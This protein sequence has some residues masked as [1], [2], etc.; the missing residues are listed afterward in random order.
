MTAILCLDCGTLCPSNSRFCLHCGI[1]LRPGHGPTTQPP[2]S[3]LPPE[4]LL[5]GRYR[6]ERQLGAGAFGRVYLAEDMAQ[7]DAPAVALKELLDPPQ[8]AE[9]D[10]HEAVVWFK[11]EVAT[12]LALGHPAIPTLRGY[13]AANPDSGPFYLAMEYIPGRT[14][15]QVLDDAGGPLPW[16]QVVA[17]GIALCDVLGYLHGQDPPCLFRDLT[18]PNIIL[19]IRTEA[20]VLIDFGLAGPLTPAHE[21]AAGTWGYVPLEQILG[22]AEPR[23]DLYALGAVLHALLSGQDPEGTFLRLQRE[24]PD[25]ELTL[26]AVFPPLPHEPQ[27]I[28]EPLSQVIARATA[29]APEDRYPDALTMAAAL[30]R[31]LW[32]P[33]IDTGQITTHLVVSPE[34]YGH[35]LTLADAIAMAPPRSRIEVRPGRYSAPLLIDKPLEIVGSGPAGEVLVETA[36]GECLRVRTARVAVHG[37]TLRCRTDPRH[38]GL[39]AVA[40]ESGHQTLDECRIESEA[41]DAIAIE[42]GDAGALVRHCSITSTH[43]T[44]IRSAGSRGLQVADCEIAGCGL[45]GLSIAG[46]QPEIRRCAIVNG[47]GAGAR[48]SDGAAGRLEACRLEG[49]AEAGLV[50]SDE[51]HPLIQDCQIRGNGGAA[52]VIGER[53]GGTVTGCDLRGNVGGPWQ[54]DLFSELRIDR[55]G[56]REDELA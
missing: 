42:A 26:G 25:L 22:Q 12:L 24:N 54:V 14:L 8:A 47:N 52:V 27:G 18:L 20:L 33:S 13:W 32:Q 40:V 51:A 6:I 29:F 34:G 10:R 2:G 41:L 1:A 3:P 50:L 5:A 16:R 36:T 53:G 9:P 56:N 4:T 38:L 19:D 11:R 45:E 17:W 30:W 31:S 7:P 23:S 43:A 46:G 35:A 49:N 37:I 28:P 39:A 21:T 48:F 15:A 55:Y 44:G